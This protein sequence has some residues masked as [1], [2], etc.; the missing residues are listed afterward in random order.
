LRSSGESPSTTLDRP[1]QGAKGNPLDEE[2]IEGSTISL[3]TKKLK[4]LLIGKLTPTSDETVGT[5]KL[6]GREVPLALK[7]AVGVSPKPVDRSR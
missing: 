5:R 1:D 3:K 2:T 7:C 4:A 6:E